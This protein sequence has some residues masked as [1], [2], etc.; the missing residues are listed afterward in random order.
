MRVGDAY[1]SGRESGMAPLPEAIETVAWLRDN[2]CRLAMLT[3]GAA[4]A[5]WQ[6]ITRFGLKD[7]FDEILVEGQVGFGKPD[8]RI[9]RLALERLNVRRRRRG[10]WV[11]I[12]NGMSRHPRSWEFSPSGSIGA[13]AAC[14]MIRPS[15]QQDRRRPE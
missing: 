9:Y 8:K 12:S 7:L 6:K 11:T 5:Q 14:P 4:A 10:W 13:D 1:S 2:G 15:V 3:N